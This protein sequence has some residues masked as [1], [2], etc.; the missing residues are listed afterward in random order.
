MPSWPNEDPTTWWSWCCDC[1]AQRAAMKGSPLK[2]SASRETA[3][4]PPAAN[5]RTGRNNGKTNKQTN[6]SRI[7]LF[8]VLS[9]TRIKGFIKKHPIHSF[10]FSCHI[11]MFMARK[12]EEGEKLRLLKM[13]NLFSLKCV[14]PLGCV[15][16]RPSQRVSDICRDKC[17]TV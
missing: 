4:G 15:I 14:Q 3:A 10:M 2:T 16:R 12:E 17:L 9:S 8:N 11:H 1:E 7:L 6:S 13:T 5:H